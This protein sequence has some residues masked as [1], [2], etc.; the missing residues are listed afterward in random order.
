M[1]YSK[2]ISEFDKHTEEL[3]REWEVMMDVAVLKQIFK[4]YPD[5]PDLIMVYSIDKAQADNL[6]KYQNFEFDFDSYTYEIG[7]Y[8]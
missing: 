4:P 7:T 1:A 8:Q 6:L 5:D 2:I 3:H